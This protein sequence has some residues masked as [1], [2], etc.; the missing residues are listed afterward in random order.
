MFHHLHREW[1]M[2]PEMRRKLTAGVV[3][4]AALV[5]LLNL[6]GGAN[7][8][9]WDQLQPDGAG[10]PLGTRWR[11]VVHRRGCCPHLG[12]DPYRLQVTQ[13]GEIDMNAS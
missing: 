10:A 8:S 13:C 2:A 1:E 6:V 11:L 9:I 5:V 12:G 7:T 4:A 3:F